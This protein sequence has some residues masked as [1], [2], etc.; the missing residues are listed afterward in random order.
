MRCQRFGARGGA[1]DLVD[2]LDGDLALVPA[3]EVDDRAVGHRH[4]HGEAG[5]LAL[6]LRQQLGDDLGGVRLL[7]DDVL[8]RGPAAPRVLGGDVG[9]PLLVGVGVDGGEERPLDP[10]RIVEDLEDG[11]RG[12]GGVRGVRDDPVL[13]PELLVVD[14]HHDGEVRRLGRRRAEDDAL[15]PGLEVLLELGA[16]PEA[17]GRLDH[18][19]DPQVAPGDVARLLAGQHRDLPAGDVEMAVLEADLVREAAEDRVEAEQVGER[20]VVRDVA[21]RLDPDVVAL[22]EDAEDV[23]ADPPESHEPD[24]AGH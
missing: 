24:A 1:H 12:M 13:G 9:Q 18:R 21:D 19:V 5:E 20:R 4:V 14:P 7:R 11:R 8:G 22:V 6:E 2:R 17:R 15:R 16:G 10:E 3:D 23:A